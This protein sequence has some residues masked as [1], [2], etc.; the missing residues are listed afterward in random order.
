VKGEKNSFAAAIHLICVVSWYQVMMVGKKQCDAS[1]DIVFY[2]KQNDFTRHALYHFITG[3]SDCQMRHTKIGWFRFGKDS[4]ETTRGNW[5]LLFIPAYIIVHHIIL[6]VQIRTQ[7]R[8]LEAFCW[9]SCIL[10]VFPSRHQLVHLVA[11]QP[12]LGL[13]R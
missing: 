1:P 5:I 13:C 12:Q 3:P 10:V 9:C 2:L 7:S 11:V 8:Q 4:E 6:K